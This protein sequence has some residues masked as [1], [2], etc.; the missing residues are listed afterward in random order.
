MPQVKIHRSAK[1]R[2][3]AGREKS[4]KHYEANKE[5]I[6]ARRR[7]RYQTQKPGPSPSSKTPEVF[8]P[9]QRN[10]NEVWI[11]RAERVYNRF[12]RY[13]DGSEI[14]FLHKAVREYLVSK[15]SAQITAQS[16]TL[17]EYRLSLTRCHDHVLQ[18]TGVGEDLQKVLSMT[19]AVKRLINWMEEVAIAALVNYDE[20]RSMYHR[21]QFDFQKVPLAQAAL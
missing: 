4:R 16:S 18:L 14:Q 8:K 5:L 21:G 2:L 10:D 15:T 13:R 19:D 11:E 9:P 1:A 12:L 17:E 6:N 7:A 20:V 3:I